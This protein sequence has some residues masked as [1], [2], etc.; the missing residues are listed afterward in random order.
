MAILPHFDTPARLRETSSANRQAW[1]EEV[2]AIFGGYVGRFPQLYD[3]T[4]ADTPADIRIED[5]VWTAFPARLLRGA[6]SQEGRWQRADDNRAEQD[7]YCEW[8]VERDAAG[9]VT[10]VTFTSEVPEYFDH[11]AN[12]DPDRLLAFYREFVSPDVSPDDIFLDGSYRRGN[13]WNG[14]TQGPIAHLV[15]T[16]NTLGAAVDLVARATVLREID[17][18]L[19]TEKQA[20]AHCADLGNPFRN[21]DPQIAAAVN[22]AAR[23]RDEVSLQD[24]IALY[25]DGISTTG[26][27]TPDG[28]DPASF[29]TVERGTPEHT[30]RAR[31]E[32]PP[33]RGYAIGDVLSDGRPISFGAQL[34]DRVRVRITALVKTAHHT[35]RPQ[36]CN[37]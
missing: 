5:I 4:V 23:S 29:W 3:P 8:S 16:N 12:R 31:Y 34:A 32:V 18:T 1:S 10:R 13:R 25:I 24:P 33:E 20:L 14:P 22:S 9:K 30:L 6:T 35:P 27:T 7:E 28:A 17:G 11:L 36:P 26:M 2:S 15:Q 21:S 37:G 19:V